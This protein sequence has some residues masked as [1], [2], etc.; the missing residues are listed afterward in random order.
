MSLTEKHHIQI[1]GV[2]NIVKKHTIEIIG[3]YLKKM[4]RYGD[5][6]SSHT[7]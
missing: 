2:I 7:S 3:S 4:T 1:L 6:V 5:A